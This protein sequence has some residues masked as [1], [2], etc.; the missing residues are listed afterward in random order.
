M[1]VKLFVKGVIWPSDVFERTV[2]IRSE[3]DYDRER[4]LFADQLGVDVS[5]VQDDIDPDGSH[6]IRRVHDEDFD[7][8]DPA[9]DPDK[10]NDLDVRDPVDYI[11]KYG[12]TIFG[13]RED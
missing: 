4:Q 7:V 12:V 6:L 10:V 8:L 13:D 9:D 11:D 5:R 2:E 1:Q 3:E